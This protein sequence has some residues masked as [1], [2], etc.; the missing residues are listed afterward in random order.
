MKRLIH[1][2]TPAREALAYR[3]AR[4]ILNNGNNE[5]QGLFSDL[6]SC[7]NSYTL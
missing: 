1:S 4:F 3:L 7:V 6:P 5:G 2:R